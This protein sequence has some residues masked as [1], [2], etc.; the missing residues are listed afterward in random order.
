MKESQK[1][2][3][4]T[5]LFFPKPPTTFLT[6]FCRSER[7]KY[8]G[9]KSGLNWGSNSNHQVMSLTCSP[10]SHPGRALV[11]HT[12]LIL[13]FFKE[14]ISFVG[15]L[16]KCHTSVFNALILSGVSYNFRCNFICLIDLSSSLN[17]ISPPILSGRFDVGLI[18]KHQNTGPADRQ[19]LAVRLA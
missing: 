14:L 13:Y 3:F 17:I 7:R 18:N 11:H 19:N 4:L 5:Q 6:C 8:A 2:D 15:S 10:L 9:K 16:D 1:R 12:L